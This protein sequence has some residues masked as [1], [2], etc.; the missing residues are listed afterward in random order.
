MPLIC[1]NCFMFRKDG[2]CY[3]YGKWTVWDAPAC[4]GYIDK[5]RL[6]KEND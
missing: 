2:L 6:A 1:L 4:K 3:R 5:R